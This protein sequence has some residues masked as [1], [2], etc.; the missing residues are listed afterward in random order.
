MSRQSR[1]GRSLLLN[2][3]GFAVLRHREVDPLVLLLAAQFLGRCEPTVDVEWAWLRS[4]ATSRF[5]AP[6]TAFIVE[7]F[8]LGIYRFEIRLNL[9]RLEIRIQQH[10]LLPVLPHTQALRHL[11]KVIVK[12]GQ[13]LLRARPINLQD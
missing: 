8:L 7:T 13:E 11:L 12:L 6:K 1:G 2:A 4:L 10:Q 3:L 9:N 5:I